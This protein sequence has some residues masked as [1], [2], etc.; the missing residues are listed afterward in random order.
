M[1][2]EAGDSNDGD[3]FI[4]K[5]DRTLRITRITT[6]RYAFARSSTDISRWV[7]R[8]VWKGSRLP[9]FAEDVA[10]ASAGGFCQSL[11]TLSANRL[12]KFASAIAA[13]ALRS[14]HW[15]QISI[16]RL[17]FDFNNGKLGLPEFDFSVP[18]ENLGA[19]GF[20]VPRGRTSQ[21]YQILDNFTGC[22]NATPSSSVG[23]SGAPRW[24][25]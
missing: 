11:S 7:R 15:M 8:E 21:T 2:S 4:V 13:I 24:K 20:S 9:E 19:Q 10:G 17:G 12:T 25:F 1:A 22:V 14:V 6:G 23:S 16:H 3:N 5:V 18:I